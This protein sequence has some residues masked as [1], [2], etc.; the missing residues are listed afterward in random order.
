VEITSQLWEITCHKGSHSVNCHPVTTAGKSYLG[1]EKVVIPVS[2]FISDGQ[3][4]IMIWFKSW[5]NRVLSFDLA[6]S[7]FELEGCDLT[8]I[9]FE[10]IMIWL[11]SRASISNMG[12]SEWNAVFYSLCTWAGRSGTQ[13]SLKAIYTCT[14]HLVKQFAEYSH[15][16][17]VICLSCHFQVVFLQNLVPRVSSSGTSRISEFQIWLKLWYDF[18]WDLGSIMLCDSRCD[19]RLGIKI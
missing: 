5:L 11:V 19:L 16:T 7:R 13:C 6:R 2:E 12:W 18:I 17:E 1:D 10:F 14:Y 4:Q 8:W 15:R 3:I 9:W